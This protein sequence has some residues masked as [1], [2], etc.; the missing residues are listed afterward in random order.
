MFN[1]PIFHIEE[2]ITLS[3][4]IKLFRQINDGL[5]IVIDE[6]M[7]LYKIDSKNYKIYEQTQLTL[8][9]DSVISISVDNKDEFLYSTKGGGLQ[10]YDLNTNITKSIEL[11]FSEDILDIRFSRDGQYFVTKT[12]NSHLHVFD[13]KLKK[14][15]YTIEN[16]TNDKLI[17]HFFSLDSN[18]LV[19]VYEN[20]Y[21]CVFDTFTH[22]IIKSYYISGIATDGFVY[23]NNSKIFITTTDGDSPFSSYDLYTNELKKSDSNL[24]NAT[25]CYTDKTHTTA[26][27]GTPSGMVFLINLHNLE[28]IYS[29]VFDSNTSKVFINDKII[30]ILLG[31][32]Q[33]YFFDKNYNL[34]QSLIKLELKEFKNAFDLISQNIFLFMQPKVIKHLNEAWSE[35]YKRALHFIGEDKESLALR[36]LEPFFIIKSKKNTYQNVIEHKEYAIKFNNAVKT[37]NFKVAYDLAEAY[38]FLKHSLNYAKMEESWD[39]AFIKAERL[40]SDNVSAEQILNITKSYLEI[41]QKYQIINEM[42]R[43]SDLFIKATQAIK[44]RQFYLFYKYCEKFPAL[45]QSTFGRK[46]DELGQKIYEKL[47][48]IDQSSTEFESLV[49]HLKHFP[50]F[51]IKADALKTESSITQMFSKAKQDDNIKLI[52]HLINANPFLKTTNTYK[53]LIKD[54][55]KDFQTFTII[56]YEQGF[57][58]A[59]KIIS[60]YFNIDMLYP[61]IYDYMKLYYMLQIKSMENIPIDIAI[62]KY[63]RVFGDDDILL[64]LCKKYKQNTPNIQKMNQIH[65]KFNSSI[66]HY[67]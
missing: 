24:K 48:N 9:K 61:K 67:E 29:F 50:D 34:S 52:Y 10:T 28:I 54:T 36:M 30:V 47:L 8:D 21:V 56:V 32:G 20:G 15:I 41:P 45:R 66:L 39:E 27:C 44:N 62:T 13:N 2:I 3:S 63:K 25:S 65:S 26:I 12:S 1:N 40:L 23:D 53:Q 58:A 49:E 60:K 17:K 11:I 33:L 64:Y 16:K 6:N 35:L 57:D 5:I 4:K 46:A 59:H 38:P 7:L 31:N 19:L 51:K 18:L 22:N 37:N 42:I 55:Q 43:N 14:F